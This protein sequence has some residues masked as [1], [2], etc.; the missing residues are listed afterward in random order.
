VI[1]T[2][3]STGRN[4]NKG[5][6]NINAIGAKM[7]LFRASDVYCSESEKR[8]LI[9]ERAKDQKRLSELWDNTIGADDA[10]FQQ[11]RRNSISGP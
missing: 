7:G 6:V 1:L 2:H 8:R 11:H 4:R 10:T 3:K 9:Y 5:E